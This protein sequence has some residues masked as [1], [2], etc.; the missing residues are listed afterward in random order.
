MAP[1]RSVDLPALDPATMGPLDPLAEPGQT[2]EQYDI[3]GGPPRAPGLKLGKW[4]NAG[5][6]GG[7]EGGQSAGELAPDME[8]VAL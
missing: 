8:T 2:Y 4:Q 6:E 7:S 5:S 3:Y 1:A